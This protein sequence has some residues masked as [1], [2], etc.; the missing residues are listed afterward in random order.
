MRFGTSEGRQLEHLQL[1]L[2]TSWV[3]RSGRLSL[4]E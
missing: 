2:G 3:I 4:L 1:D